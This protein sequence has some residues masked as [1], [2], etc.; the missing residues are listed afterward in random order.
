[1]ED[2]FGVDLLDWRSWLFW[3][4]VLFLIWAVTSIIKHFRD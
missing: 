4:G 1:M 2:G 3:M